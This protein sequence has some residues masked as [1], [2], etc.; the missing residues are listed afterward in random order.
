[1]LAKERRPY[2]TLDGYICVLLYN[3]KHWSSFLALIGHAEWFTEDARFSSIGMR[4]QHINDLY[5]L[6][7]K[8]MI[9]RTTQDWIIKLNNVDIPCMILHDLNSLTDDPHLKA[10]GMIREV[11]HPSEGVVRQIGV[12]VRL[13]GTPVPD[14]QKPAPQLGEHSEE[15]LLEAG[16][17]AEAIESLRRRGIT[18]KQIATV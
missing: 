18:S 14:I 5:K 10:V 15:V 1:L 2:Q 12:P 13:S 6:V 9:N 7:S 17:S 11:L 4:T 16:Y 8:A 3:D